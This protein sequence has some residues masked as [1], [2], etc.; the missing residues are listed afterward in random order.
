MQDAFVGYQNDTPASVVFQA[1]QQQQKEW[2]W[3]KSVHESS[4]KWKNGVLA[5]SKKILLQMAS[6]DSMI[7]LKLTRLEKKRDKLLQIY[8][9]DQQHGSMVGFLDYHL[10]RKPKNQ[11]ACLLQVYMQ[12]TI[13][14]INES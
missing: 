2:N 14:D 5:R 7:R 8:Y 10:K 13:G 1:T 11:A 6:P 12:S 4:E 3:S 9:V